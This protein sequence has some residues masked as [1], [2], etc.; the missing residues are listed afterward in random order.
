MSTSATKLGI[1]HSENSQMWNWS[2]RAGTYVEKEL[3]Q[4]SISSVETFPHLP[5]HPTYFGSFET[6]NFQNSQGQKC[7][8]LVISIRIE[9][10]HISGVAD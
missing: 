5:F 9:C 1:S 6:T 3:K 4:V 10:F 2:I 7:S 8:T